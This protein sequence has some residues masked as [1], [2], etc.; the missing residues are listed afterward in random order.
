MSVGPTPAVRGLIWSF[1]QDFIPP[2]PLSY[3][4]VYQPLTPGAG[5]QLRSCLELKIPVWKHGCPI[6]GS[7]EVWVSC[8]FSFSA[9]W[10]AACPRHLRSERGWLIVWAKSHCMTLSLHRICILLGAISVW[11]MT[12]AIPSPRWKHRDDVFETRSPLSPTLLSGKQQNQLTPSSYGQSSSMSSLRNTMFRRTLWS[13]EPHDKNLS[14]GIFL[15]T[16]KFI[17]RYIDKG[18]FINI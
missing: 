16:T 10:P 1:L 12:W 11:K 3:L 14:I 17:Y 18:L 15:S 6:G 9:G 5:W 4:P 7:Q 8:P 2:C 13:F